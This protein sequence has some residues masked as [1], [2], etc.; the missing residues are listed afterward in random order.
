MERKDFT[1][2]YNYDGYTLYY[3]GKLLSEFRAAH[4]NHVPSYRARR[5]N[6]ASQAEGLEL[7]IKKILEGHGHPAF[8]EIIKNIDNLTKTFKLK[9]PN[10]GEEHCRYRIVDDRGDRVLAE[11]FYICANFPIKPTN[12]FYKSELEEITA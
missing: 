2:Q 7:S 10:A 5:A 6:A 3:K 12:V 9:V 4:G 11:E 1:Y 8:K